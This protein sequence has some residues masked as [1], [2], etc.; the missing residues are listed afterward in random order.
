M[1]IDHVEILV[2][3]PSMEE[4]LR[5]LLPKLLRDITFQIYPH[6][7]K[8]ELLNRLPERLKG[9]SKWIPNNW[10]IVVIVD[11]DDSDCLGLKSML[12]QI[13]FGAGLITRSQAHGNPYH[14]VNRLAIEE[15]EAWYFGD[16]DAVREA[17]P[18]VPASIPARAKYRDPDDISGGTWEAFEYVLQR[19]GY[20][21]SGL[22]KIEAARTI[23]PYMIPERNGSRSFQ[24]LRTALTEMMQA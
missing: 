2:E 4:V 16:W 20:F 12:E 19:S 10:R 3:E 21:K 22:R 14:V 11:R 17:Y 8:Q 5:L 1:S 24:V 15:L 9:Y 18:K 7:C 13:A 23:A 6:Q